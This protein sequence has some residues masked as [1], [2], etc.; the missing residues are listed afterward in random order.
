[1]KRGHDE[2]LL[3]LHASRTR[4]KNF[5]I[6]NVKWGTWSV[7]KVTSCST[8]TH[9]RVYQRFSA[10][11]NFQH[12]SQTKLFIITYLGSS[13]WYDINEMDHPQ[14]T[15][16]GRSSRKKRQAGILLIVSLHVNYWTAQTEKVG[17]RRTKDTR[18]H[19]HRWW[20][21]PPSSTPVPHFPES[22]CNS[23]HHKFCQGL[24]PSVNCPRRTIPSGYWKIHSW[25]FNPF[26]GHL[27]NW[28][29]DIYNN[30]ESTK[31]SHSAR[32]SSIRS[33]VSAWFYVHLFRL[34]ISINEIYHSQ[35]ARLDRSRREK[36][37]LA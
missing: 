26:K 4:V 1:M 22:D 36:G 19:R 37:K 7:S 23:R 33:K 8:L 30:I 29:L 16:L 15:R 21:S 5:A 10:S 12:Q 32:I 20:P 6:A 14:G 13:R 17:M 35:G 27:S 25:W 24:F 2:D 34:L 31:D 9:C 3:F 18:V 11:A 28:R